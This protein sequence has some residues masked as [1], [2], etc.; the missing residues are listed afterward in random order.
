MTRANPAPKGKA[1]A[2][3]ATEMAATKSKFPRLKIIPPAK[4]STRERALALS[5][6]WKK[7]TGAAGFVRP[8]VR[9]NRRAQTRIPH[10]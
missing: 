3:P 5:R 8:A 6:L 1:T 2:M 7:L 9:P 10:M 4:A